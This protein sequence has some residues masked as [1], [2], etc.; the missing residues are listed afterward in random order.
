MPAIGRL[1]VV[2]RSERR[3]GDV[4]WHRHRIR[5]DVGDSN[6]AGCGCS[7]MMVV[8]VVQHVVEGESDVGDVGELV[9]LV[10]VGQIVVDAERTIRCGGRRCRVGIVAVAADLRRLAAGHGGVQSAIVVDVVTGSALVG[11]WVVG[12]FG[13]RRWNCWISGFG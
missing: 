6:G 3:S 10:I 4:A 11:H 13:V 2:V 12:P 1:V 7:W 9:V 8:V 5:V